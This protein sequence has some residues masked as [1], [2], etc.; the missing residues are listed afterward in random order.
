MDLYP[1]GP[2][3][4]FFHP[5]SPWFRAR[6]RAPPWILDYRER[7]KLCCIEGNNETRLAARGL[8][9]NYHGGLWV[10]NQTRNGVVNNVW[11]FAARKRQR[12]L[13]R[14]GASALMFLS[15]K[16]WHEHVVMKNDEC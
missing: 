16:A 15:V 7:E 11:W 1:E 12:R 4:N 13:R 6:Q 2:S 8:A 5:A 9:L 10:S 3:P 14:D